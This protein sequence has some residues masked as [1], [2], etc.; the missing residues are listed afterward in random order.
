MADNLR[1]HLGE[2]DRKRII[3]VAFVLGLAELTSFNVYQVVSW[4][5]R[6][7]AQNDF[8]LY[9]GAA[10]VG[11]ESGWS[12]I[13]DPDLQRAALPVGWSGSAE[14]FPYLN[15]PP[16][17][18]L[19]VPLTLLPA[20]VAYLP[21]VVLITLCLM[22]SSQLLAPPGLLWRLLF[23]GVAAGFLPTFVAL[24][25]GQPTPMIGLALVVACLLLE[26]GRPIPAGVLVAALA[27]KPQVAIL[28]PI[29]LLAARYGRAFSAWLVASLVLA[30]ISLLSLNVEGVRAYLALAAHFFGDPYFERWSLIP[31]LGSGWGWYL[32]VLAV[33]ALTAIAGARGRQR[34]GAVVAAGILGSLLVNHYLT[35]ADFTILLV[36]IWLLLRESPRP[37]LIGWLAILWVAGWFSLAD[38]PEI[39]AAELATLVLLAA[40]VG[41]GQTSAGENR[42]VTPLSLGIVEGG[43][44]AGHQS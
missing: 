32:G 19:V 34:P 12:R 5:P 28:V 6:S 16:L 11:L 7:L 35:P 21:W 26:R 2:V 15:P 22:V 41:L 1:R 4:V 37:W 9:Y 10:K 42:T 8:R 31:W 43:I 40:K 20:P 27:L 18:W 36:P 39:V 3:K 29:A 33:V 23:G 25:Y 24:V 17:A 30:A 38:A 13:Y 44:G 14:W